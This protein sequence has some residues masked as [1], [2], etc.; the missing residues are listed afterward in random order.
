MQ[1]GPF[2]KRIPDIGSL[3]I[4]QTLTFTKRQACLAMGV[5]RS[6]EATTG[7]A[8]LAQR[9]PDAVLDGLEVR[10][11]TDPSLARGRAA[12]DVDARDG[13]PVLV[14]GDSCFPV[15]GHVKRPC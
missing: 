7:V 11:L 2:E 5:P 12:D 9:E 13:L 10:G 6:L 4:L 8:T 15:D 1:H 14:G 3:L